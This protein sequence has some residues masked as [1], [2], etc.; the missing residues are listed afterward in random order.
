MFYKLA[1]S[2]VKK[3][4]KEYIVYF[5]TLA[6]GVCLFY[7]FNSIDSQKAMFEVSKSQQELITALIQVISYIS[8]FISIILAFLVLYA[9]RFLIKRRK[10]EFGIYM[11]LGMKKSKI[12]HI[13][14]IE[15]LIIGIFSL[16]AGLAVGI[17]ASQGLSVLTAKLF[18]VDLKSLQ[19]IFSM[20][21]LEKTIL[22]FGIIF[23]VVM[24]FNTIS[25]SR[26][27]LIDLIYANKKN[28]KLR[29]KKLWL[30]V[31]LFI[32]SIAMIG[33]AYY[34]ILHDGIYNL[35]STLFITIAIGSVGTLLFFM[36]LAGFLLK[37]IQMNKKIYFRN[38][39]MFV[40][41]Q[42]N[43]KV[44][45]NFVSMSMVCLM[46]FITIA[47]LSGG[48][49]IANVYSN[50][51]KEANPFDASLMVDNVDNDPN[52]DIMSLLEK[53]NIPIEKVVGQSMIFNQY[54]T[55]EVKYGDIFYGVEESSES[56]LKYMEKQQVPLIKISEFNELLKMQGKGALQLNENQF[57]IVCNMEDIQDYC[58]NFLTQNG[59]LN[60][61]ST[62]L[63][64]SSKQVLN[65]ALQDGLG[66]Q[67]IEIIVPDKVLEGIIPKTATMNI[68]YIGSDEKYEK[69]FVSMFEADEVDGVNE[70]IHGNGIT[71]KI[72]YEISIG[73]K[74]MMTYIAV[75]IGIVF[76]IT[77]A[78]VL[79]LQQLSEA[80]DNVERYELLKK[81]GAEKSMI[82]RALFTQIC[83]Y[84]IVPL[85]LAIVHS[86]VGIKVINDTI[87]A[88]GKTDMLDNVIAVGIMI[89]VIY[90]GY[91]LA[92]FIG[93]KNMIKAK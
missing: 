60:I 16:A 11:T 61:N 53:Y 25:I 91:L 19:F 34:R 41:R 72:A 66:K 86:I 42:I 69:E 30:P 55:Q 40:L 63:T 90:G 15:T 68:N 3:S 80:S 51:M 77:S 54:N 70:E 87:I 31:L 47:T 1:L 44:N 27:K 52:L 32:I 29:F 39:N 7:V 71:R 67:D 23:I 9:N 78:A 17:F 24:I 79:A 18:E 48:L 64:A 10:K 33:L 57:Y 26:Y 73:L 14:I 92:T 36:S 8:I 84:F 37:L 22:Y 2:N 75:Y 93:A 83:I 35:N 65:Y 43:S 88:L 81:I 85:S 38:L 4:I 74:V 45:T 5:L 62:K 59:V 13:V 56:G 6:F 28:E 50:D 20:E 21:A 49:A 58:N 89:L 12:S 46:L 82:N 76:L